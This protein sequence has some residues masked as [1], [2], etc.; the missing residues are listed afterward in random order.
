MKRCRLKR[1]N[2]QIKNTMTKR[3]E[4]K[5]KYKNGNDFMADVSKRTMLI[6]EELEA[7]LDENE[8]DLFDDISL[9]DYFAVMS[10]RDMLNDL[11]EGKI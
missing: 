9:N 2:F 1:Y 11:F 6:L 7:F 3:E 10:L 4:I 5:N 8:D